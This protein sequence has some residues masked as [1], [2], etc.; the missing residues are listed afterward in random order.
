M[1]RPYK[2]LQS[3]HSKLHEFI[4]AFFNRIENETGN[5]DMSFFVPD[6]KPI[7]NRHRKIIKNRCREIYKVMKTWLADDRSSFCEAIRT[8]NDIKGICEGTARP[9]KTEQIPPDIRNLVKDLFIDLYE[10]VLDGAAFTSKYKTLKDHFNE[11]RKIN[12]NISLCPICGISPLKTQFDKGREQYD[13]YFPKT[14]YPLSSVNFENLVPTCSECNSP[15]CK[16]AT[17]PIA[18]SAGK[19]FYPFDESH[20]GIDIKFQ[21]VVD[22]INVDNIE[23]AV[24]FACPD[25]RCEEMQAWRTIYKIDDRYKGFVKGRIQTWYKTYWDYIHLTG[26][27][28][29]LRRVRHLDYMRFLQSDKDNLL[30]YFR[31]PALE[32]YLTGSVL[33]QAEIEAKLYS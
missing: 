28:D 20:K 7:A 11:F 8:S 15:G 13:H 21:I 14:L 24:D 27:N 25:G 23:W 6:F 5:F 18:V 2:Y 26:G 22:N 30:D 1:L 17:D 29:V 31:K 3:D 10:Q 12:S 32:A 19:F 4:V 33:S 9:L 16:G